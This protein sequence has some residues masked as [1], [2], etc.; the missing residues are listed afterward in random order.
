MFVDYEVSNSLRKDSW[1]T[2]TNHILEDDSFNF[3]W[4]VT[5]G[6]TIPFI[7]QPD[8]TRLNTPDQFA[9]CNI[10]ENSLN[11]W[12]SPFPFA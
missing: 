1:N 11:R 4:N 3:L 5:L 6:G 10:R 7:F 12:R 8:K 2:G 9:K